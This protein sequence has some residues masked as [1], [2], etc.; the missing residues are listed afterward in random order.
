MKQRARGSGL[1]KTHALPL[2]STRKIELW[3][4]SDYRWRELFAW[5]PLSGVITGLRDALLHG[6]AP[7]I[8]AWARL[9]GV[10]VLVLIVGTLLFRRHEREMLDHV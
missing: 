9:V 1:K 7:T 8:D 3:Q 4:S 6:Q 5:N 2:L 10:T